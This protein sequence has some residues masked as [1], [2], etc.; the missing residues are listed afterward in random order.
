MTEQQKTRNGKLTAIQDSLVQARFFDEVIMGETAQISVEGKLLQAE[1]LQIKPDKKDKDSGI[2][3]MQVFEDLT[4]AKI[5][6]NVSFTG[7]PLSVLLGPGLLTSVWD[8]LQNALYTLSKKDAYLRPGMKA[9]ALDEEKLWEF[10]PVVKPGDTLKGGDT[11]G[12]VPEGRFEHK[13]LVPFNFESCTVDSIIEKKAVNITQT[14][15][16]VKDELNNSRELTLVFRQPVKSPIPFKE[17][18]IPE[19]TISTGVRI[20]D[21]LAPVAYG[22]TVGNPGPF[23][24]GKT[25]LQHALCKYALADIIVMAACGERAGEAVE[26]FKDFAELEDP[27]TGESLMNRMCI[28]GNT[29]SMPVAAREASVLIAL[30]V[31]EYYRY[32]GFNVVMLADSTS[33]WAQAL[34]ERSGRQGDIPGPEAF[35]M[36]I[37]DQIKGMYQRAGADAKTGGSLTF[38][39]TVSP[40]GGNFQEPVTQATMDS[41]GGFWGLSQDRA[42]AKK[43]PA[44]DPLVYTSSVYESFISNEDRNKI[45]ATLQ[46][47]NGIDQTIS[48]IGLKKVPVDKYILFQ[49]GLT[50]DFC[51]L[52]QNAFHDIDACTRPERLAIINKSVQA[53]IDNDINFSQEDKE[54]D[55]FKLFIKSKFDNLRQWWKNWNENA[56]SD[57]ELDKLPNKISQFIHSK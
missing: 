54:D 32:Q 27:S 6:D 47:A 13:I 14:V 35:P 49:K 40:A 52:Q 15:A 48:T 7:T 46:E 34:R 12:T 2:V 25:V 3:E 56:R 55:E 50:I 37:P 17:R 20:I 26:V 5:G 10:T 41:T 16:V 24:A 30:T 39:G 45:L 18:A 57:E 21:L 53:L 29:S 9:P 8:G 31:G 42:D 51:V 19:Q 43:Y 44:I 23:G 33:R 22:G 4:G 36:D 1:V 11:I 38:I 28:F